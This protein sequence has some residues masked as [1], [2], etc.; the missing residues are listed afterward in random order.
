ML[1]RPE[2]HILSDFNVSILASSLRKNLEAKYYIPE[3]PF[4][5]VLQQINKP[6]NYSSNCSLLIWTRP[7]KIISFFNDLINYKKV[8]FTKIHAELDRFKSQLLKLSKQCKSVFL[9]KWSIP[10]TNHQYGLLDWSP[11]F[12]VRN[13]LAQM[14]ISISELME[15]QQNIYIL[16]TDK[17]FQNI[18]SGALSPKMEY[19]TKVPY[20]NEVFHRAAEDI[21]GFISCIDGNLKKVVVLDLDNTLWGGVIGDDGLNNIR[22][23]GHDYIGEAFADFQHCLLALYRRGVLLAI[24]S[25]NN[26]NTAL[27]VIDTHPEMILK[28]KHF[29]GWKINWDD[30]A[31]NIDLLAQELN[32]G[33]D[34][35][36]FIDDNPVERDRVSKALPKVLVP[37]WPSD[38][39]K[40]SIAL[41]AMTCFDQAQISQEDYDRGV[42]SR[43]EKKRQVSNLHLDNYE[44]WLVSLDTAIEA[45]PLNSKNIQRIAQLY[46]KTNQFNLSTRRLTSGEIEKWYGH[47]D[48]HLWALRVKDKFGN[49]GL[50]GVIGFEL[51][52][53]ISKV[54]D[55]IL[56]CRVMGRKIEEVMLHIASKISQE[57]GSD[58]LIMCYKKTDRNSPC[59]ESLN[60]TML[61]KIEEDKFMWDCTQAYPCP[62]SIN[63]NMLG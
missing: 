25:K 42:M 41:K 30:K 53:G 46:N 62:N 13:A 54:D 36:V 27:E 20:K 52:E 8:P 49:L 19:V 35:F 47:K 3:S 32:L 45:E 18:N 57:N 9:P 40:Y 43:E 15:L 38:P 33:I 55:M 29:S 4:G 39:C 21:S 37:D 63:V 5:Q 17:W 22:L 61:K 10:A 60:K 48:R 59:L 28:R 34:A 50:T 14:N 51:A 56:S 11:G 24:A 44:E 1:T 26:E 2:L 6:E 31:K 7:E 16:E 23:G 58:K 12:G